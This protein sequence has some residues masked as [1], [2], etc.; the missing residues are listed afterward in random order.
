MQGTHTALSKEDAAHGASVQNVRRLK[1][2]DRGLNRRWPPKCEPRRGG[3]LALDG[4]SEG[5]RLK[6]IGSGLQ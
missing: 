1:S 2:G 3:K 6:S 5:E 4:H